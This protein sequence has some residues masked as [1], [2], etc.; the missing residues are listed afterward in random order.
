M[1]AHDLVN[2]ESDAE[3]RN[4]RT[5]HF[6]RDLVLLTIS[7]L[8]VGLLIFEEWNRQVDAFHLSIKEYADPLFR[9]PQVD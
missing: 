8:I 3:K 6:C 9:D 5:A 2:R 1:Q 7:L 4:S